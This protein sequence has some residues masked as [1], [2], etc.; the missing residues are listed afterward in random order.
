MGKKVPIMSSM[1]LAQRITSNRIA[2]V[3]NPDGS[4]VLI[5]LDSQEVAACVGRITSFDTMADIRGIVRQNIT[6]QLLLDAYDIDKVVTAKEVQA[7]TTKLKD[8]VRDIDF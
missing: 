2:V 6:L 8:L 5:D 3:F 1:T 7:T 4:V